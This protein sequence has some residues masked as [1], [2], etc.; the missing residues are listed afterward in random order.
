MPFVI[1]RA[2]PNLTT[3]RP[4]NKT[5]ES[6]SAFHA[7]G[8]ATWGR[9]ELF[10]PSSSVSGTGINGDAS[11][12]KGKGPH[13]GGSGR[14]GNSPIFQRYAHSRP[15]ADLWGSASHA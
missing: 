3:F 15:S 8:G 14:R 13:P 5:D 7:P 10:P 4:S 2:M 12:G 1:L 6:H 9:H 11:D